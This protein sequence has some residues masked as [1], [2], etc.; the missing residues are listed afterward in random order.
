MDKILYVR[1]RVCVSHWRP[2]DFFHGVQ[3]KRL[4]Y[5]V[6]GLQDIICIIF[7]LWNTN[8]CCRISLCR[9]RLCQTLCMNNIL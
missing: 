9:K 5:N 2:Q 7:Y 6:Q 1:V 4:V 8:T 3:T